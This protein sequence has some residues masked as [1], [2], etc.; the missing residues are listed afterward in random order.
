MINVVC[1]AASSQYVEQVGAG[2]SD[3]ND[4]IVTTLMTVLKL[5]GGLKLCNQF[6][7]SL[8]KEGHKH[9]YSMSKKSFLRFCFEEIFHHHFFPPNTYSITA[10][11]SFLNHVWDTSSE[12]CKSHQNKIGLFCYCSSTGLF[13]NPFLFIFC[14]EFHIEQISTAVLQINRE[15]KMKGILK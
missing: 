5:G 3:I 4:G 2:V 9:T 8:T 15:S 10:N 1:V 13:L 14:K 11:A 6:L 7:G 12:C